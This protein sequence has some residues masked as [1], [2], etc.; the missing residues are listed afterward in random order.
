MSRD[1]E[2]GKCVRVAVYVYERYRQRVCLTFTATDNQQAAFE[3]FPR[4]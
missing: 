1:V 4:T 3:G 2:T